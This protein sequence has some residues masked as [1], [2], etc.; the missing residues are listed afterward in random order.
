MC[1]PSG[2]KSNIKGA[3]DNS[4]KVYETGSL[5]LRLGLVRLSL[6]T[7]AHSSRFANENFSSSSFLLTTLKFSAGYLRKPTLTPVRGECDWV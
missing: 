5:C 1:K 4:Q 7:L 3:Y 2:R 6:I